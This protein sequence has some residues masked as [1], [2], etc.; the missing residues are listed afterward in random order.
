VVAVIADPK[1]E[2]ADSRNGGRPPI[3]ESFD[4]LA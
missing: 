3:K 2:L 1:R 4:D